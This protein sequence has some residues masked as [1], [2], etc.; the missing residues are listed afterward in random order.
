[1]E[2]TDRE[3]SLAWKDT[4]IREKINSDKCHKFH[5]KQEIKKCLND[6]YKLT[7]ESQEDTPHASS[8]QRKLNFKSE[9]DTFMI[10]NQSRSKVFLPQKYPHTP[11]TYPD[12]P[13]APKQSSFRKTNDPNSTPSKFPTATSKG[14]KRNPNFNSTLQNPQPSSYLISTHNS[15]HIKKRIASNRSIPTLFPRPQP[16]PPPIPTLLDGKIF[17]DQDFGVLEKMKTWF[18]ICR[19]WHFF[20]EYSNYPYKF[21]GFFVG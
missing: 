16:T 20:Q 1:M 4:R 15:N 14:P 21:P 3:K 7:T 18:R 6:H 12:Q 17:L 11:S 2:E 13:K 10:A 5:M 8:P 19:P 9:P